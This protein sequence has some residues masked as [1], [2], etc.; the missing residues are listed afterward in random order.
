MN[1]NFI[2]EDIIANEE[3]I[4]EDKRKSFIATDN[5]KHVKL[6][7]EYKTYILKTISD[8]IPFENETNQFTEN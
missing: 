6:D 4:L 8:Q 7:K 2:N 1:Q 3:P 5:K